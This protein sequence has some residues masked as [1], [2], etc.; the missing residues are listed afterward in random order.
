MTKDFIVTHLLKSQFTPVAVRKQ[1]LQCVETSTKQTIG[2]PQI[3]YVIGEK[4]S[5]PRP[6]PDVGWKK[7]QSFILSE[8]A[9]QLA[10]YGISFYPPM[11]S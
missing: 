5:L 6:A 4:S 1:I 11:V 8:I 9:H 10:E 7:N 2:F 3:S